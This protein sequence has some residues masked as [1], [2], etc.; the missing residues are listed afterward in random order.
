MISN[1]SKKKNFK[2]ILSTFDTTSFTSIGGSLYN[3]VFPV[4]LKAIIRDPKDYKKSYKLTFSFQSLEDGN[5]STGSSYGIQINMNKPI[6]TMA[7]RIAGNIPLYT[8][9]VIGVVPNGRTSA[10]FQVVPTDNEPVYYNDIEN[11]TSIQVRVLNL[12]SNATYTPAGGVTKSWI[13]IL[14][15]T[16]V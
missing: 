15:F 4:D 5:I 14:C 13:A 3:V 10:R 12:G 9:L 11:I 1:I 7:N 6:N 8:G 16:E 2:L